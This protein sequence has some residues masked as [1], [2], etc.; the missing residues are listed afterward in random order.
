[1][2]SGPWV[3]WAQGRVVDFW[4]ASD[5][6]LSREGDAPSQTEFPQ[7][8]HRKPGLQRVS[9]QK[10]EACVERPGQGWILYPE[11]HRIP[12]NKSQSR[13]PLTR[14]SNRLTA[15]GNRTAGPSKSLCLAC[16]QSNVN[17][18]GCSLRPSCSSSVRAGKA[19]HLPLLCSTSLTMLGA[20]DMKPSVCPRR[21]K[22]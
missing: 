17:P 10:P 2:S 12:A 4:E 16:C 3:G 21:S 15:F 19:V 22:W 20:R 1:M 5:L 6:S 18:S 14:G 8:S 13:E 7:W 9:P 11:L